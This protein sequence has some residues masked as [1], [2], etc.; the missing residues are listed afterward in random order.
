[1]GQSGLT[2]ALTMS[3][4]GIV[5]LALD[6]LVMWQVVDLFVYYASTWEI[7]NVMLKGS[8]QQL[9]IFGQWFY[10]IVMIMSI[11]FLAYPVI[12][13]IKRHRYMDVEQV[14][15]EGMYYNQ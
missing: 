12:F 5:M 10:Y 4:V 13:V 15:D 2:Q 7:N 9:M 8:M 11:L 14:A 3:A 6:V 1:M